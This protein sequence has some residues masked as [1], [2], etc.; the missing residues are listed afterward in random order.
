MIILYVE[1]KMAGV[2]GIGLGLGGVAE[3]LILLNL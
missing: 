2:L 3:K 1:V